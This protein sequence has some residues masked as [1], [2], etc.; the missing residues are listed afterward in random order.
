MKN[1]D[2][3]KQQDNANV[4]GAT[5]VQQEENKLSREVKVSSV[6]IEDE[7]RKHQHNKYIDKTESSTLNKPIT[8]NYLKRFLNT[9]SN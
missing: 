6:K 9:L 5:C 3:G 1:L 7:V 2:G 4:S 8:G